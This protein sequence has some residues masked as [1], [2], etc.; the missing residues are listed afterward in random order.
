MS[1]A[2]TTD[3]VGLLDSFRKK[4]AEFRAAVTRFAALRADANKY[5]DLKAEYDRLYN[6]GLMIN[7][8]VM[9]IVNTVDR[10]TGFF[11]NAW[12]DVTSYF[13]RMFGGGMGYVPPPR[14]FGAVPIIGAAA[15]AGAVA[16]IGK[17]IRDVYLFERT[18]T[19]RKK[20]EGQGL[21]PQEAMDVMRGARGDGDLS[22]SLQAVATPIALG[23]VALI[24]WKLYEST[25]GS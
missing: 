14:A 6:Q 7:D 11:S 2:L 5:P 8:T 23:I 22:E 4:V 10:V 25:R 3:D 19:E 17:W 13:S 12:G 16:M 20:L 1:A 21:T 18:V 9:Y 24:A 15:I